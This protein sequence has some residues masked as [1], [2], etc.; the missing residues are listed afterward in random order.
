V[1]FVFSGINK[2]KPSEKNM[3]KFK[4]FLIEQE[5]NEEV[6]D[7]DA[8]SSVELLKI[9]NDELS[10]MDEEEISLFGYVLYNEFFD[11][12][13][14]AEDNY[15]DFTLEDVQAMI[16]ELGAE[17]YA[18]VADLLLPDEDSEDDTEDEYEDEDEDGIN[19]VVGR[20]MKRKNMNRKKRKFFKKT[21]AELRKGLAA[22]R[23]ANRLNKA[24]RKKYFRV[25]K[26]RIAMYKKSRAT[27][28][29]K[30]RHIKKVR[31]GA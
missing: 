19:E 16:A 1:A 29:K 22:R 8:L 26:K 9:I 6:V 25:N 27:A 5:D 21:K 10:Q 4:D 2:I 17:F 20:V 12:E 30:G 14:T 7:L 23:K 3:G 15:D 28:I 11:D 13:E 18:D 24:K 31:R